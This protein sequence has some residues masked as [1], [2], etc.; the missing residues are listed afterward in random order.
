MFCVSEV[1]LIIIFQKLKK[2]S[3]TPLFTPLEN[4]SSKGG[5]Q[6]DF[7]NLFKG[8]GI[9]NYCTDQAKTMHKEK[10]KNLFKPSKPQKTVVFS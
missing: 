7:I 8:Y 6:N 2:W 1:V 9:Q 3:G 4:C 5:G 10:R